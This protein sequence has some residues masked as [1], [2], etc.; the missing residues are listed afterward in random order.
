MLYEFEYKNVFYLLNK[1]I[2]LASKG[3]FK[4]F[5]SN[6]DIDYSLFLILAKFYDI[7]SV[8]SLFLWEMNGWVLELT[9]VIFL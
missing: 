7:H 6:V 2:L 3:L 9:V 4:K 1:Y 8:G 5:C